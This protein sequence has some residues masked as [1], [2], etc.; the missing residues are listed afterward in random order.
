MKK[1]VSLLFLLI[2]INSFAQEK[3][4]RYEKVETY[5]K[6]YLKN[7]WKELGLPQIITPRKNEVDLYEIYYK[8]QLPSGKEVV[9]TGMYF[10]PKT[11]SNDIPTMLYNH[12]TVTQNRVGYDYNGESTI[13]KF[14]AADGYA[15]AW[16][17]YIGLGKAEGFHPYQQYEAT[18][19]SGVDL[20]KA[21]REINADINL[22]VNN[23]L[24]IT[25][26]SQGGYST[27]A[28]HKMI[29]ENF[30]TVFKVTATS[31]MS[32]AYDMSGVQSEVM[33][34]EY[35]QPH[36]LPYLLYGYN[37]IY[38]IVE[39]DF[40]Q[41][42]ASPYDSIIPVYFDK[43]HNVGEINDILPKIPMQMIK[44][45]FANE[46]KNN[47]DFKFTKVLKENNLYNWLPEAPVQLCYCKGDEEVYYKNSLE[48][49]DYMTKN[50]AKH[51]TKR[52]VGD[53][54]S[55]RQCADYAALY[56]KFYFDSFRNGNEY[57]T[58]GAFFKNLLVGAVK[59]IRKN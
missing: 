48:A 26:Y 29:Q 42:F 3:L 22:K 51:I 1:I 53:K 14:F 57:G 31:P 55:H 34:I 15:V 37:K 4:I 49:Y 39:K 43:Q 25:G 10:V 27:M 40:Y 58:K 41:I 50:G 11:N 54:F 7:M 56:T 23:Q 20:L 46:F 6:A 32:G 30:S 21:I 12:G 38:N 16:Q 47:P 2:S 35:T 36:Y 52:S 9:A 44:P 8:T 59:G 45:T 13:C 19:Q 28:V 33:E 17:D 24:F 18:G 5:D